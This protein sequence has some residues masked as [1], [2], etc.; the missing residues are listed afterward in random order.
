MSTS[1]RNAAELPEIMSSIRHVETYME[2]NPFLWQQAASLWTVKEILWKLNGHLTDHIDLKIFQDKEHLENFLGCSRTITSAIER[3]GLVAI[4]E[5]KRNPELL[6]KIVAYVEDSSIQHASNPAGLGIRQEEDSIL[7]DNLGTTGSRSS[8]DRSEDSDHVITRHSDN[9]L[10]LFPN[11][12]LDENPLNADGSSIVD[13]ESHIGKDTICA[14]K[15]S[16]AERDESSQ[17]KKKK[18]NKSKKKKTTFGNSAE[19]ATLTAIETSHRPTLVLPMAKDYSSPASSTLDRLMGPSDAGNNCLDQVVVTTSFSEMEQAV[20]KFKVDKAPEKLT[21]TLMEDIR[22]YMI[23]DL[24]CIKR[25]AESKQQ[26]VEDLKAECRKDLAD[27]TKKY[28]A[29]KFENKNLKADRNKELEKLRKEISILCEKSSTLDQEVTELRAEIQLLKSRSVK[30][31]SRSLPEVVAGHAEELEFIIRNQ[32]HIIAYEK[33]PKPYNIVNRREEEEDEDKPSTRLEFV[34]KTLQGKSSWDI[35]NYPYMSEGARKL[36]KVMKK[37]RVSNAILRTRCQWYW[38]QLHQAAEANRKSLASLL[39]MEKSAILF[40]AETFDLKDRIRELEKSLNIKKRSPG[41]RAINREKEVMQKKFDV[42]ESTISELK[43]EVYS[44]TQDN[45]QLVERKEALLRNSATGELRQTAKIEEALCEEQSNTKRFSSRIH[46]LQEKV[47]VLEEERAVL[48]PLIEVGVAV[49]KRFFE[50]AKYTVPSDEIPNRP[51]YKIIKEGN[52]RCHRAYCL[53]DAA[54]FKLF[55]LSGS[56]NEA[57]YS[58]IYSIDSHANAMKY[59]YKLRQAIDSKASIQTVQAI[60]DSNTSQELRTEAEQFF[61]SIIDCWNANPQED[62]FDANEEVTGWLSQLKD[63]EEDIVRIDRSIGYRGN[64]EDTTDER[65][66]SHTRGLGWDVGEP[67]DWAAVEPG[68]MAG[69]NDWAID[70][71]GDMAGSND[72]AID[73][74]GDIAGSSDWAMKSAYDW[75]A[76]TYF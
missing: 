11:T 60:N 9:Q 12:N 52:D 42:L 75:T 50:Q 47:E 64:V 40:E 69:S 66:A 61:S 57:L 1:A 34:F 17:P 7:D 48:E 22:Q 37:I 35:T 13:D 30:E 43:D 41:V 31:E 68:D 76:T 62:V 10:S 18:K 46:E 25:L 26:L 44:L 3:F 63:L 73:Q 39:E 74:P 67:S 4:N 55:Y 19:E 71:P 59:P 36:C 58:N 2:E 32:C 53:T 21:A 38:D 6:S 27:L 49:R 8:I 45:S 65:G 15:M 72:W 16:T 28:E 29:I 20:L 24:R 51:D 70:Q 56:T 14:K 54:L 5:F 33:I 23:E